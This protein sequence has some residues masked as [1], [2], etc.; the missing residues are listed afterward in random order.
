[1]HSLNKHLI[2][3]FI[4]YI[5]TNQESIEYRKLSQTKTLYFRNRPANDGRYRPADDGRYRPANDGKYVHDGGKYI[6]DG[7]KDRGLYEGD[8]GKYKNVLAG[9]GRGKFV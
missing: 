3:Y 9:G 8:G 6:H 4:C 7:D 2:S 5:G 1:M